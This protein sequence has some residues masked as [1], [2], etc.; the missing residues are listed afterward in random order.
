MRAR[1]NHMA[2]IPV[3]VTRVNHLVLKVRDIDRSVAFYS[4]VFGMTEAVPRYDGPQSVKMAFLRVA[5]GANHHDLG[6]LEVGSDAPS[7]PDGAVGLFH[8]ALEVPTLGDLAR[9]R[10]RLVE[11]EGLVREHDH[12]ATKSIYGRDPDGQ[13]FEIMWLVPP[14]HWGRWAAQAPDRLP[15]DFDAELALWR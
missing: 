14:E 8:F 13:N 9:A 4:D 10:Q 12:G 2:T 5:D 15:L 1:G 11:M 6:L 3:P 7:P